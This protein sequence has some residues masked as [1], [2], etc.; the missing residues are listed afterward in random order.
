MADL[1]KFQNR[2]YSL[3]ERRTHT[4][5]AKTYINRILYYVRVFDCWL[6]YVGLLDIIP[7]SLLKRGFCFLADTPCVH[8]TYNF[9]KQKGENA[10]ERLKLLFESAKENVGFL[11]LCVLI[12]GII[13][14]SAYAAE[15]LISK[16][17]GVKRNEERFRVKRIVLIAMLSGV[18][19]ILMLF[20]FPLPFLPAFYALDLSELPV[21]IGAF[22]L[23]PVAGVMIE[24]IKIMLNLLVNGTK[25]AFVGEFANF[26][27]GCSFIIPAAIIYYIK[28]SKKNA[29][30]GLS[31]GTIVMCVAAGF[32]NAFLLLP[33]YAKA[34]MGMESIEPLIEMGTA[35]NG[36]ITNLSTF[37]I[38]AVV[39][40]NFIKCVL[41]TVVTLL[42]Y[43]KL[44]HILKS[45]DSPVVIAQK[46]S[47][48][49]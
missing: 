15:V 4:L 12:V 40:F 36:M 13:I 24:F 2:Q 3:D 48:Q 44:S 30:I 7:V 20:E 32:L 17:K 5:I 34:F 42:I 9:S 39:P 27:V 10:M 49:P 41:V 22:T 35:L 45:T 46:Y 43:K 28:K 29:F 21:V 14:G 8:D 33:T 37:V 23:G 11:L 31:V 1:V 38:F 25:T 16:A 26:L 47:R 18:A 6:I 19:I